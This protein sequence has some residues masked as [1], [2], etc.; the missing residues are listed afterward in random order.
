MWDAARERPVPSGEVDDPRW[1]SHLHMNL[2]P[3]A[4]GRGAG[5]QLIAAWLARLRAVGSPGCH[6]GTLAENRVARAFFARMGFRDLDAPVMVPG[7]RL[8]SGGRMHL[9]L[10]VQ[11]ISG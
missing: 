4:R 6:L 8:R 1:P 3:E 5:A 7:M 9:Q 11:D 2:L 10:M